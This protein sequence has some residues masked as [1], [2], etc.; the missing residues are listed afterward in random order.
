MGAWKKKKMHV[1][2][3]ACFIIRKFVTG[4]HKAAISVRGE[5]DV[6]FPPSLRLRPFSLNISM[7]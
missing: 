1:G 6:A 7:F 2:V 4:L 5:V 3:F